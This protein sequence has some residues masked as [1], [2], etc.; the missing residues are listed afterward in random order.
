MNTEENVQDFKET[1]K[2]IKWMYVKDKHWLPVIYT[3][4][5]EYGKFISVYCRWKDW[6]PLILDTIMKDLETEYLSEYKNNWANLS[7]RERLEVTI[8]AWRQ[9]QKIWNTFRDSAKKVRA[10]W[11]C[12]FT[13]RLRPF[14]M[15]KWEDEE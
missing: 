4:L 9:A 5:K 2:I 3:P 6:I 14:V 13:I 10:M 12:P 1:G 7:E 11:K 8:K 15:P